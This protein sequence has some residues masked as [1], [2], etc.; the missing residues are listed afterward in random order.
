MIDEKDKRILEELKLNSK[1][2]TS[3]L[4]KKLNIPIT[5]VHN[6]IKRMERD[7]VIIKYTINIDNKKIGKSISAM[8]LIFLKTETRLGK[9]TPQRTIAENIR[10]VPGV[11]GVDFVTGTT[12]V[13]AHV[14][15]DDVDNLEEILT[16][17]IRVIEGINSTQTMLVLN[18]I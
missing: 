12:D 13:I 6:R 11:T 10:K 5:T 15:A 16:T 8:I 4:S 18:R 14:L 1:L 17:R 2:A 7:K 3:Q 9:K